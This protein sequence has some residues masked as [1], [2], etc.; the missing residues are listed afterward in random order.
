MISLLGEICVI[1][2][3]FRSVGS[4][5]GYHFTRDQVLGKVVN[6]RGADRGVWGWE[7]G[8]KGWG[9]NGGV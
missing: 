9:G 5:D 4:C 8:C 2:T 1:P 3:L 6:G 7:R